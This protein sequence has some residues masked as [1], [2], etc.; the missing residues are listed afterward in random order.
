[1][2]IN[3]SNFCE[4]IL[5]KDNLLTLNL[6]SSTSKVYKPLSTILLKNSAPAKVYLF[7]L[8]STVSTFSLA[9][10]IMSPV[11]KFLGRVKSGIPS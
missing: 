6:I 8:P 7:L 1:M 10:A 11:A 9:Y 4:N 5:S 3:Y 2:V